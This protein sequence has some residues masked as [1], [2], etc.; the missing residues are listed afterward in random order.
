MCINNAS[1]ELNHC[2]FY[3]WETEA[4]GGG[5]NHVSQVSWWLWPWSLGGPA[6]DSQRARVI[7]SLVTWFLKGLKMHR[8]LQS[9]TKESGWPSSLSFL[10]LYSKIK[11]GKPTFVQPTR[12][13]VEFPHILMYSVCMLVPPPDIYSCPPR[14]SIYVLH[15]IDKTLST[16]VHTCCIKFWRNGRMRIDDCGNPHLLF[17][18]CCCFGLF[19]WDKASQC[20]PGFPGTYRLEQDDLELETIILPLPPKCWDCEC[21]APHLAPPPHMY[22]FVGSR[23]VVK[24]SPIKWICPLCY[25]VLSFHNGLQCGKTISALKDLYSQQIEDSI[26]ATRRIR[27]QGKG[28]AAH[29]AS[30]RTFSGWGGSSVAIVLV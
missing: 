12:T 7:D 15:L 19:V 23:C 18:C 11:P 17:C 14:S 6:S 3:R 21:A 13:W 5:V 27:Q 4:G 20:H 22:S 30:S 28:R 1:L 9:Q 16:Y 8:K 25:P 24:R 29:S 2:P 26:Y 10:Q